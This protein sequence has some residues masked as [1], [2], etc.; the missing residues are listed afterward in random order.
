[1]MDWAVRVLQL[2]ITIEAA[3]TPCCP[4]LQHSNASLEFLKL[5]LHTLY[6]VLFDWL[7]ELS[8]VYLKG[9]RPH[10]EDTIYTPHLCTLLLL[11]GTGVSLT[12]SFHMQ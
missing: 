12:N 4:Y 2:L 3:Y 11:R 7:M 6:D 9:A 1:M 5:L 8:S 10:A